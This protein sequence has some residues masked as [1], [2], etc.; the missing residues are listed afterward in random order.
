MLFSE[1]ERASAVWCIKGRLTTLE[2]A[3]IRTIIPF[4]HVLSS[5]SLKLAIFHKFMQVVH[6]TIDPKP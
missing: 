2:A 5:H 3:A 4:H 1:A 6:E